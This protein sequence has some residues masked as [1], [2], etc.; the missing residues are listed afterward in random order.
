METKE[1]HNGLPNL[2]YLVNKVEEV[3]RQP[4]NGCLPRE[5]SDT[6]QKILDATSRINILLRNS[7]ID[8]YDKLRK[9]RDH[10]SKY[11][12]LYQSNGSPNS[13]GDLSLEFVAKSACMERT[14]FSTFFHD[15]VGENFQVWLR[16][17][18]VGLA[19][20]LMSSKDFNVTEI[21]YKVGYNGLRPFERGFKEVVKMRPI[22]FRKF[23]Q[24][25]IV[26]YRSVHSNGG[27]DTSRQI[28]MP[29]NNKT[30][31]GIRQ[32]AGR[33]IAQRIAK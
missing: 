15:K 7:A 30:Y 4:S 19:M 2:D 10:V 17:A 3:L 27:V 13:N 22:K 6:A 33:D 29:L 25:V 28:N 21:A 12:A 18:R 16:Y 26:P 20:E 24:S 1:Q 11:L 5:T 32:P 23:I 9:A 14:Y 8:Y 31:D